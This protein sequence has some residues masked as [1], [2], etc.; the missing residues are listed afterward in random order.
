MFSRPLLAFIVCCVLQRANALEQCQGAADDSHEDF[1]WKY[2]ASSIVA[3]GTVSQVTDNVVTFQVSCTLK[4][5]LTETTIQF[6]QFRESIALRARRPRGASTVGTILG[7]VT[8]RTECHYLAATRK[9]L[10]FVESVTTV[11]PERKI[12]Y[13]LADL[14]E[15][16]IDRNTQKKFF[17]E[18]CHDDDDHGIP[19]TIFYADSN[20]NKCDRFTATCNGS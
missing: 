19:M 9:Y 14:E 5:Q 10:V 17:D 2:N 18:E 1:A 20:S 6:N 11:A 13:R 7:Q 4:G 12:V 3:Y 8:N 16:E 15:I